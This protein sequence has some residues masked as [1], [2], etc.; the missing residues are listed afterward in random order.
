MKM[1]NG[2]LIIINWRNNY[3]KNTSLKSL[4][5]HKKQKDYLFLLM[6]EV[7]KW[8]LIEGKLQFWK[9]N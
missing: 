9:K 3:N 1:N 2:D 7:L 8:K 4:C 6:R 5:Y